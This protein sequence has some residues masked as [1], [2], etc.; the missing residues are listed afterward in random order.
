MCSEFVGS[1]RN[2]A[3]FRGA[4]IG[5]VDTLL[6]RLF[7]ALFQEDGIAQHSNEA[8]SRRGAVVHSLSSFAHSSNKHLCQK[9]SQ[10][11]PTHMRMEVTRTS[12]LLSASPSLIIGNIH[13]AEDLR[14]FPDI[15][16]EYDRSSL[17]DDAQCGEA[18][19]GNNNRPVK[20]LKPVVDL[21]GRAISLIQ[22]SVEGEES[23]AP[24][25]NHSVEALQSLSE[26]YSA[27]ASFLSTK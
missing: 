23:R 22:G 15:C 4:D 1:L 20:K 2:L 21:I 8:H 10:Y 11:A 13:Q 14:A 9:F 25:S 26:W 5:E 16:T 18:D 27:H 24:S 7:T 17:N 3:Q 6:P 19:D 12:S